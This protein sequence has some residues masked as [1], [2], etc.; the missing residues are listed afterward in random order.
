MELRIVGEFCKI[1]WIRNTKITKQGEF[2]I[3]FKLKRAAQIFRALKK[4]I[5]PNIVSSV[6]IFVLLLVWENFSVHFVSVFVDK[7][8]LWSGVPETENFLK[9]WKN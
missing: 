2:S 4:I 3:N 5:L 7:L 9:P 8:L 1:N 6:L